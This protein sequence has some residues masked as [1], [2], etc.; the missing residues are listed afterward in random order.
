MYKYTYN[1]EKNTARVDYI[2][3]NIHNTGIKNIYI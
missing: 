3:N 1:D 2:K